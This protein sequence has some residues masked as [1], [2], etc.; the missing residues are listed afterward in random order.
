MTF[1]AVMAP[2]IVIRPKMLII[3]DDGKF[4]A[5]ADEFFTDLGFD[6]KTVPTPEAAEK[7][8][9]EGNEYQ[10]VLTDVNFDR[11][12]RIAG[13]DFVMDNPSLFGKAKC[14]VI[15]AGEWFTKERRQQLQ[16]AGISFA[17]KTRLESRVMQISKEENEKWEKDIKQVIEL[18]TIPRIQ[19][20]MGRRVTVAVGGTAAAIAPAPAPALRL[21]PSVPEPLMVRLKRTLIQWLK[22]RGDLDDPV[23]AYGEKD[24]SANELISEVET[25]SD[26][27]FEHILMLYR[28]FEYSLEIEAYEPGND[29]D[30]TE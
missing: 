12:S 6:V 29:E 14:V 20:M 19:G 1:S 11:L 2:S 24:Y 8:L 15:S 4:L 17:D 9:K 21:R 27:G 7:L 5:K 3:D 28:E 18:E 26:V 23:F 25:E 16:D 13:H 10:I 30:E 22:T